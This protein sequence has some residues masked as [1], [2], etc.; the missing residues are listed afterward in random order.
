M[1]NF[2]PGIRITAAACAVAMFIMT[3]HAFA[4]VN[5]TPTTKPNFIIILAD[6]LGYNDLGCFGSPQIRTPRIDRM[7]AQGAK[8]TD[9]YAAPSCTPS[10]AALMTASYPPR[11]GFGDNLQHV[12]GRFS[13]SQVVHPDSPYGLNPDENTLPEILKTV[14][15][16]TGMVGKWHLGDAEKFNP[17]HHGFDFFFGMPYSNDMKPYYYLRGTERLPERPDNDLITQRLTKEALGYIRKQ[18][19]NPFFLYVAHAMPHT[20]LGASAEFKG[21]SPRGSFGDAVEEVDWSVGQILDALKE[22]GID[23]HTMVVFFSDNGPWHA[24]GE[25]GGSATPLRNAKGS[26][27][28]GG[29]RVPCVMRWPGVIPAGSV[30]DEV[31]SNM[32]FL[33]TFA[34]LAGADIPPTP[35]IDGKNITAL[36]K[37]PETAESPYEKFFYYFGNQLH[38]VRSGPWKLRVENNLQNENVY[39]KDGRGTTLTQISMP[40]ALYNLE[41]DPG[42]QKNVMKQHPNI[43]KRLRGYIEEARKDLGDSLTGAKGTG[44]RPVGLRNKR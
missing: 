4:A 13:P 14:G 3:P 2:L 32:D 33:P 23:D 17:V 34:N 22:L 28:E 18:K 21:K 41:A 43:T 30:C 38:A 19:D 15:Y 29:I 35:S 31:A 36:L 10:R 26:T 5:D 9:F 1:I 24:R 39:R 6:D 20:P 44:L 27:Y 16:S 7:A 37:N 8:F 11:V 42:E 40:P 25:N 12:N